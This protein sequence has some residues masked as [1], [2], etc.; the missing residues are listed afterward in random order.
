MSSN[1]RYQSRGQVTECPPLLN[2]HAFHGETSTARHCSKPLTIFNII[3]RDSLG[4]CQSFGRMETE[5]GRPPDGFV[6]LFLPLYS[7][8]W[9]MHETSANY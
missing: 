9:V 8:K 5:A 2:R 6:V 3:A 4:Q 7:L 1:Y